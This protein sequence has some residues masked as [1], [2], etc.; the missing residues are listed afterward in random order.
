MF[1]EN[2]AQTL[3]LVDT[4]NVEAAIVALS[5]SVQSNGHW[6]LIPAELHPDHPLIQM[7]AV[8]TS[9]KQPEASRRF[10]EFVNSPEGHEIMKKYGFILPGEI[11]EPAR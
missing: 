7:A 1:G 8:V 3:T 4:G 5:L 11:I 9:S 6:V 10:M 2:V